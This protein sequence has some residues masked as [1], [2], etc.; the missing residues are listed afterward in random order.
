MNGL[1]ASECVKSEFP[2]DILTWKKADSGQRATGRNTKHESSMPRT[3]NSRLQ[4]NAQEA[5]LLVPGDVG[6]VL[7]MLLSLQI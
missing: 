6:Q 2:N 3:I 7:S 5:S 4:V 1:F